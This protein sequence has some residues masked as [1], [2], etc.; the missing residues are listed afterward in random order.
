MKNFRLFVAF[1]L[2]CF[3]LLP[4]AHAVVPPPDGG[5]P[6]G[7]TAEGQNALLSLT[8]G[9]NNTAVGF[10]SLKNDLTGSYNTG[11]GSGALFF[12]TA[13]QN[14]ATGFGALLSNTTGSQNTANGTLALLYN[15]AGGFNTAVG[16][17]SLQSNHTGISN[18]A[19]GYQALY[20]NDSNGTGL[21][22]YNSAFGAFALT[23]NTS[24]EANSA[25]G[26]GAMEFNQTGLDNV[27]V[28]TDALSSNTTGVGNTAIGTDALEYSNGSSNIALGAFAGLL[29]DGSSNILIGNAGVSGESHTIRIGTPPDQTD[30]YISGVYMAT[31]T[32][33]PVY[34]DSNGHLGTL[35]SSRRYKENIKAMDKASEALFA[36]K[37]VTFHYKKDPPS[38]GSFGLIAEEVAQ[39]S[40]DLI[41]CDEHGQPQTVRYEAVNAM[42]L[43]EFLKE[44]RKVKSLE[45]AMADQQK[46]N[47]AMRAML[48]EQAAQIQKVSAQLEMSK[49]ATQTV[50]NN[51]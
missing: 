2:A 15:T 11:V 44:H 13:D 43:N 34:V 35:S 4:A 47:A 6:N 23:N 24:G 45:K 37:P 42:L 17:S 27:A 28:G 20:F 38:T 41:T 29:T 36:L 7:N 50:L 8:T 21:G 1:T 51:Q 16:A 31:A 22:S 46:E 19:T 3:A 40:P 9:I 10:V 5:Y 25:F 49:P 26:T 14:T 33:R 48:K 30:A 39:V 18:T 32:D 12:N